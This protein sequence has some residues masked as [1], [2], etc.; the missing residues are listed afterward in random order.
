MTN[1]GHGVVSYW[2]LELSIKFCLAV[3]AVVGPV[4]DLVLSARGAPTPRGS[5][6]T[7]P[8]AGRMNAHFSSVPCTSFHLVEKFPHMISTRFALLLLLIS[9]ILISDAEDRH[10][11]WL[12]W[13][14]CIFFFHV[15][16]MHGAWKQRVPCAGSTMLVRQNNPTASPK[17]TVIHPFT[18]P[19]LSPTCQGQSGK[20]AELKKSCQFKAN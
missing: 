11:Y 19:L 18:I 13:L 16:A 5:S 17:L 1:S 14:L 8:S 6:T 10:A 9:A 15:Q 12:I 20:E 4:L 2:L 3:V 7:C